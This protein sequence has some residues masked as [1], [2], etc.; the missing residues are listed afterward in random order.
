MSRTVT[1]AI[2]SF[3]FLVCTWIC[4]RSLLASHTDTAGCGK[5]LLAMQFLVRGATDY[6]EPGV[7]MAFEETADDLAKNVAPL[8]FNLP[9]LISRKQTAHRLRA[10]EFVGHFGRPRTAD[11]GVC[12]VLANIRTLQLHLL[13]V[14]FGIL[15][16]RKIRKIRATG[17]H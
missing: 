6:H 7:F 5:T 15:S 9:A 10:R 8:G 13:I 4:F 3:V 2:A 14:H 16:K 1:S 17:E 11:R 12:C